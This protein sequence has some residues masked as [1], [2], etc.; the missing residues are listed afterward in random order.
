ML[1]GMLVHSY[2]CSTPRFQGRKTSICWALEA[3]TQA[4]HCHYNPPP[5]H[6]ARKCLHVLSSSALLTLPSE[7]S[8]PECPAQACP[9]LSYLP[10]AV[11]KCNICQGCNSHPL[12]G[13]RSMSHPTK[14]RP[15]IR[16]SL[17]LLCTSL[18]SSWPMCRLL[19]QKSSHH[20]AL[21]RCINVSK[22]EISALKRVRALDS[23][24]NLFHALKVYKSTSFQ[25][26]FFSMQDT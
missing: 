8:S 14:D 25:F 17:S 12:E 6:P 23:N 13:N 18:A 24:N 19:S 22:K 5:S 7:E 11:N 21:N 26:I 15:D 1:L 2:L 10:T 16:L 4:E 3:K 9:S 20:F